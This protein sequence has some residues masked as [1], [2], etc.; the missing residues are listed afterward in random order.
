MAIKIFTDSS[1]DLTPELRKEYDI[2]YFRMS[3]NVRGV[4]HYATI[5][6]EDYTVEQL[7]EWIKDRSNDIRTSQ[8]SYEEI[9]GKIYPLLKEGHD[10]LYIGCTSRLTGSMNS[11]NLV[12]EDLD[13]EFPDRRIVGIDSQRANMAL[14]MICIDAAKERNKGASMDELI[15]WIKDNTQFYNQVG[16]LDTLKWLRHYG[17]VGGAAAFFADTFNIKPMIMSDIHGMNYV[18]KKVKGTKK[19]L[20]ESFEYVKENMIEGV[21]DVVYIGQ[22]LA[23]EQQKY[24]KMR[25]ENELHLKVYCYWIGA[26]VGV[27]CGPG[28]YGVYFRGKE[29]TVDSDKD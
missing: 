27:C 2:L 4:D 12:K 21:T 6:Y 10:I 23:F 3:I 13:K 28:M 19:S 24:L 25:I 7:Y 16:S 18:Y 11:F 20:I 14:G 29:V 17:R 8:L 26:I 22:A 15:K 5:D 9:K 1:S